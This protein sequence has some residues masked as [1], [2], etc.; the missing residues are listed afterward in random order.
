MEDTKEDDIEKLKEKLKTYNKNQI[1]F[2][3]PHFTQQL[4]LREG[5]KEDVINNLLSPEK[6]VYSYQEIGKYGDIIHCLHFKI[7][8]TKTIRLPVIFDKGNEKSLYILTYIMRY[9]A[10]KNMVRTRG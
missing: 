4:K 10:W 2:N 5:N 6:L 3:E 9:R 8:N 7:S 1:I